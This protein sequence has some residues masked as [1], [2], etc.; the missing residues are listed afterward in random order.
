[1]KSALGY[2]A[3]VIPPD[4]IDDGTSHDMTVDEGHNVTLLCKAEGLP[5][6]QIEWKRE[7]KRP[8]MAIGSEQSLYTS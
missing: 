2:L 8:F 7:D 1:M 3:I 5:V 4:I 6:P